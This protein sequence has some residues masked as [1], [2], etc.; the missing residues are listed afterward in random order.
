M[1]MKSEPK[2]AEGRSL[3]AQIKIEC[4]KMGGVSGPPGFK[5]NDREISALPQH[6]KTSLS[7]TID[8]ISD[9]DIEAEEYFR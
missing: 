7:N 3:L 5:F 1:S 9:L 8:E 2:T 6:I 4:I